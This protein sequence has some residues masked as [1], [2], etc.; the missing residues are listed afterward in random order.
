MESIVHPNIMQTYR[1][2]TRIKEASTF[3]MRP[4]FDAGFTSESGNLLETWL[5]LE[6]CNKGSL[7]VLWNLCMCIIDFPG[8]I[9]I[10]LPP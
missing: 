7:Q 6:Y 9:E 10:I 3:G 8:H 5:L 4:K 1:H 2:A